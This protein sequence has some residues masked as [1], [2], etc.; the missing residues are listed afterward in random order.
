[1]E[2]LTR[3]NLRLF[4]GAMVTAR[5]LLHGRQAAVATEER[6]EAHVKITLPAPERTGR[7]PLEQTLAH[8]RS[9][10]EFSA[11]PL[12]RQELSQLLWAAQGITAPDGRR[13]APS[14][15]ALYALEVYVATADGFFH[16]APAKHELELQ[17]ETDLRPTLY[18]AAQCRTFL[19]EAAAVFVITAVYERI[20]R[21]YG[22]ERSPLY[23]HLEAGHVAQNLLL[24]AVSLDLGG[25]PV[26]GFYEDQVG[27]AISL[28][29]SEKALYLVAVG[30][31]L[32]EGVKA[33]SE[34]L[35]IR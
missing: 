1:M 31:P 21:K 15:G 17:S 20:E 32:Q 23:V 9:L 27:K 16:Y 19:R 13:T 11:R 35:S 3:T 33:Q 12:S 29:S 6:P 25:V 28:P 24:Q 2:L 8:R 7:M 30:H 34:L 18:W 14:A 26:G 5:G 22:Q 4:S 10:R